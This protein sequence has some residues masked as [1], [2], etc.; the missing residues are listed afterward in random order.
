MTDLTDEQII[1]ADTIGPDDAPL[2]ERLPEGFD[3]Q[4][5]NGDGP[6]ED[7]PTVASDPSQAL[8]EARVD[9][10]ERIREGIPERTFVP[11]CGWLIAGKRY[12]MPSASGEGKSLAA[13]V[14][15]VDV[16][17]AG[18][19][20]AILDVENGGDEYARRLADVLDARD[21]DGSLA[22]AC[23]E[24]LRYYEWPRLRIDWGAEEWAAAFAGVDLVVFDS[25]RLLLSAAGSART[26]T[27]TTPGS[28]TRC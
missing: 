2:D 20:V 21:P 15:A 17:E 3:E 5:Q 6:S 26:P 16:V 18:G 19:T 1:A 24:R 12:L 9:L 27:T 13:L 8:A 25:S 22:A 7:A 4:I 14:I 11:G 28:R 23:S 10:V